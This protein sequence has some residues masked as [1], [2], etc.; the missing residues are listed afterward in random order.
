MPRPFPSM[1]SSEPAH[2]LQKAPYDYRVHRRF[3]YTDDLNP[4]MGRSIVDP[5][6]DTFLV[7]LYSALVIFHFAKVSIA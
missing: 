7:I 1:A 6:C 4:A 2:E 3:E 5:M